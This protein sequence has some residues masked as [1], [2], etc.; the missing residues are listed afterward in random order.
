[1]QDD[2]RTPGLTSHSGGRLSEEEWQARATGQ[3]ETEDTDTVTASA[4]L[5]PTGT[6]NTEDE[7]YAGI[8]TIS[9]GYAR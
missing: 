8:E 4:G 3:V 9:G 7:R 6:V 5:A 1:M 2:D